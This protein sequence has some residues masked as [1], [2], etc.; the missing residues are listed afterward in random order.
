MFCKQCGQSVPDE[1]K[2]CPACG[3]P[4]A[5]AQAVEETAAP[6]EEPVV[7]AAAEET[8][9]LNEETV[10]LTEEPIAVETVEPVEQPKKAKRA[11]K[12]KKGLVAAIVAVVAVAALAAVAILTPLKNIFI[13][14]MPAEKHMQYVYAEAAKDIGAD[15]GKAYGTVLTQ[16]A[17]GAA[18]G[19]M[20]L[21]VSS[22]LMNELESAIGVDLGSLNKVAID[23]AFAM[24]DDNQF[25]YTLGLKLQD[26]ELLTLKIYLDMETGEMVIDAPGVLKKPVKAEAID[27]A[28]LA[29]I[30]TSEFANMK[31]ESLPDEKFVSELIPQLVSTAFKQIKDVDRSK[32]TLE[33][34]GVEQKATCFEA[35][36]TME[37]VAAMAD[38]VL[39]EL[40]NNQ[41]LEDAIIG[42]CEDNADLVGVDGDEAYDAFIDVLDEAQDD[43]KDVD[44]DEELFTLI[45][46]AD[47]QNDLIALG[48]EIEGGE[49][50]IG[51]ATD[52][53]KVGYEI[54]VTS[55]DE[56]AM[57]YISGNGTEKKD[58]LD[59]EFTV[60]VEGEEYVK[61][62]IEG[63]DLKAAAEGYINGVFTITPGKALAEM[64]SMIANAAVEITMS[65]SE[66]GGELL[67]DVQMQGASLGTLRFTAN[68]DE[69]TEVTVPS[70]AVEMDELSLDMVDAQALLNKLKAAGI[71]EDMINSF[72]EA[73][74]GGSMDADVDSAYGDDYYDDYL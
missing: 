21:K 51:K 5:S 4:T 33:V 48:V 32:K 67:L 12:G 60:E 23:Y 56:E 14:L 30:P 7:E 6:V 28:E 42:F 29:V 61:L 22:T 58:I 24:D 15:F 46:W 68:V 57:L 63:Y 9:V 69:K 20:E 64:E 35:E 26:K 16:E 70:N 10:V 45:T 17:T 73:L 2:F 71:T 1:V 43:L 13:G 19:T 49:I 41:N 8:A 54:S 36:I 52:G 40:K 34:G 39:E 59:A 65:T 47:W 44:D 25:G 3:T 27:P 31:L 55:P 72:A 18:S 37:T 50:F 74:M 62:A 38:A 11:K 53:D 66:S